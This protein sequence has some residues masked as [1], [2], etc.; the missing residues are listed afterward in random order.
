MKSLIDCKLVKDAFSNILFNHCQ[1]LKKYVHMSWASLAALSTVMAIL[2]LIWE[3][4]AR[5]EGKFRSS[6]GSVKPSLTSMESTE[7]V[8][9]DETVFNDV[10][11]K[12]V[13]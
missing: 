1:P 6:D 10:N 2:V 8:D 9:A 3:S 11:N 13:P 7:E 12:I 4:K 5:W